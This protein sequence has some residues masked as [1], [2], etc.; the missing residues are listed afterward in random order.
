MEGILLKMMIQ[1]NPG[2]KG[3]RRCCDLRNVMDEVQFAIPKSWYKIK[4]FET[5]EGGE[6]YKELHKLS[7]SVQFSKKLNKFYVN[8]EQILT[9][10]LLKVVDD[11]IKILKLK[12]QLKIDYNCGRNWYECH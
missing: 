12:V 10:I 4:T 3:R 1:S 2:T 6:T 8:D 7:T 11:T 9:P 5:E